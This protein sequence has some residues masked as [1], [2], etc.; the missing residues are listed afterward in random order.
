[1]TIEIH[2]NSMDVQRIARLKVVTN[3]RNLPAI[4]G[5]SAL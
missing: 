4:L 1:V 3:A 2:R 5:M